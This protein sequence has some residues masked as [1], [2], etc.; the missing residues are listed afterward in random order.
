MVAN[1]DRNGQK[2]KLEDVAFSPSKEYQETKMATEAM[3]HYGQDPEGTRVERER[4]AVFAQN[5]R[6]AYCSGFLRPSRRKVDLANSG[7]FAGTTPRGRR[8]LCQET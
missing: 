5:K 2:T 4:E 1:A 8:T 3:S 6:V 7:R